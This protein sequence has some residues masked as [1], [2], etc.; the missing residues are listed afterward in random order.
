MDSLS[1]EEIVKIKEKL[2]AIEKAKE[3]APSEEE[4]K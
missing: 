1:E 4:P 2:E 3:E